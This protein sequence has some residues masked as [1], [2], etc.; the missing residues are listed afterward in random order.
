M[1]RGNT[2]HL[3]FLKWKKYQGVCAHG[4]EILVGLTMFHKC[5]CIT[6]SAHWPTEMYSER[7]PTLKRWN[8]TIEDA[9]WCCHKAV[10]C[11]T[12]HREQT[13]FFLSAF[14]FF[15]RPNW[16]LCLCSSY[17][18]GQTELLFKSFLLFFLMFCFF[19]IWSSSLL[20]TASDFNLE[21]GCL[22]KRPT[23]CATQFIWGF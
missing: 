9:E 12:A 2:K 10:S 8:N 13:A 19:H 7:S 17:T 5:L 18:W 14:A 20:K 11:S 16:C 4:F 22:A 23:N 15:L 6:V 1:K 21:C 3:S